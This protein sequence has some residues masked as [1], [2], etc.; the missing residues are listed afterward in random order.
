MVLTIA[1]YVIRDNLHL[2]TLLHAP[3][4]EGVSSRHS[5]CNL[6]SK[7]CGIFQ[8]LETFFNKWKQ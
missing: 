5:L 8:E 4:L 2:G 6:Y 3:T 7:N 1:A